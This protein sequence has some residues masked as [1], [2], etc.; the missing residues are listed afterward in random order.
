MVAGVDSLPAFSYAHYGKVKKFLERTDRPGAKFKERIVAIFETL[1][2]I[3]KSSHNPFGEGTPRVA[4]VE[5]IF[6]C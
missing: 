3:I 2:K 4:P 1:H 5:F 6:I